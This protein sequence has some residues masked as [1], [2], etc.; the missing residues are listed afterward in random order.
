MKIKRDRYLEELLDLLKKS[1]DFL[2]DGTEDELYRMFVVC[3]GLSNSK[4]ADLRL[5]A[6][7]FIDNND[8]FERY[9]SYVVRNRHA[10][11]EDYELASILDITESLNYVKRFYKA[12]E[13]N[14]KIFLELYWLAP[15]NAISDIRLKSIGIEAMF[16]SKSSSNKSARQA[17]D[18]EVYIELVETGKNLNTR[19]CHD[20][21][22]NLASTSEGAAALQINARMQDQL[23]TT[24]KNNAF[25]NREVFNK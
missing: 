9:R 7:I 19:F 8:I 12:L 23:K 4:N 17:N 21:V 16:E 5:K 22:Y 25:L 11:K 3:T 24:E 1:N 15:S 18:K 2:A 10:E 13:E 6:R 14:A 20:K